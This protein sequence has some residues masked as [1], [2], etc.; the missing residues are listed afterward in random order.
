MLRAYRF[1]TLMLA[2]WSLLASAGQDS[3]HEP[4]Q[5]YTNELKRDTPDVQNSS[6]YSTI[7][8]SQAKRSLNSATD[9]CSITTDGSAAASA[10]S[11][12]RADA[13]GLNFAS[14]HIYGNVRGNINIVVERNAVRGNITAVRR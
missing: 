11:R 4:I 9:D 1:S 10:S 2:S 12:A 8:I 5:A 14:P 13:S 7:A 3:Y 6:F